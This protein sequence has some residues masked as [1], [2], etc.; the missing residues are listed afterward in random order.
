MKKIFLITVVCSM[1]SLLIVAQSVGINNTTPHPSAILDIKS[2]TKGLLIPR[3]TSAERIAIATPA[4]GLLVYDTETLNVWVYK[5]AGWSEIKTNAGASTNFWDTDGINIYNNNTGNVGIGTSNPSSKFTLQTPINTGGWKHV[6]GSDSIIVSEGIGG[7]SAAIGTSTNHIFR[8]N[9]GGLGRMHIYP[10]G[11]VTVGDNNAPATDKF[12]VQSEGFGLTHT[13]TNGTVTVGTWIGN[14]GGAT[15]G[16][17]GTKSNH[18]FNFFANNGGALMTILPN[19][20]VGIGTVNPT[21]KLSVISDLG[22]TIY[23]LNNGNGIGISGESNNGDGIAGRS[24]NRVGITAYSANSNGL[25]AFTDNPGYSAGYFN[26][27]VYTT[28]VYAGSDQKLKQ[29]IKD[30]SSAMNIINELHPKQYDYRHDGN[31]KLMNLPQGNH[32]GLIAQDVEKILPNL[33][34]NSKFETR[35]AKAHAT[36][37]DMENSE[38]IDFKTLNY[39]G[40]I[41]IIIKGMQEQQVIIDNQQKQIDILEKRLAALEAKK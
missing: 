16:W 1:Y 41:P 36:K 4:E 5:D 22:A 24:I 25:Y 38:T 31:Y 28:G 7:V 32:Y 2:N 23:S 39:T 13:N 15:G 21:Y 3:M 33:V 14:F 12:T 18:A 17:I 10:N 9:S 34:K 20:N 6:G 26:G 37:A 27:N 40:L 35:D 29:N 19:G 30:F 8:L 11:N